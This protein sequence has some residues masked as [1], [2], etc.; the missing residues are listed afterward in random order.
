MSIDY[1]QTLEQQELAFQ[2]YN[3]KSYYG[4]LDMFSIVNLHWGGGI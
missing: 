2:K 3:G 4:L 1:Y